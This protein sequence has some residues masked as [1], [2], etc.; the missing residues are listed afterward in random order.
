MK[1]NKRLINGNKSSVGIINANWIDIDPEGEY[2]FFNPETRKEQKLNRMH[3]LE[4]HS[5]ACAQMKGSGCAK[6]AIDSQ[7]KAGNPWKHEIA[8]HATM[9]GN[10]ELICPYWAA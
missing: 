7:N 10:N 3:V 1:Q 9:E 6:S 5:E 8:P 2:T 4:C